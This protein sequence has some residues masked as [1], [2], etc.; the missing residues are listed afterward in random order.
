MTDYMHMYVQI[1]DALMSDL[2]RDAMHVRAGPRNKTVRGP[3]PPHGHVHEPG[4]SM[5]HN[6]PHTLQKIVRRPGGLSASGSGEVAYDCGHS[7]DRPKKLHM[8]EAGTLPLERTMYWTCC[9]A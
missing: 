6:T 8:V 2:A 4:C 1:L 7:E 5:F 9:P 3:A